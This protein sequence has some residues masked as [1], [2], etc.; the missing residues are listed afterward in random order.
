MTF[1]VFYKEDDGA[2]EIVNGIM[3]GALLQVHEMR[4]SCA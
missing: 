2:I 1:L 4:N 3:R